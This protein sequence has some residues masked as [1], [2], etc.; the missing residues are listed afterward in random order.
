MTLYAPSSSVQSHC[1]RRRSMT[2]RLRLLLLL[3]CYSYIASNLPSIDGLAAAITSSTVLPSSAV[4]TA[5]SRNQDHHVSFDQQIIQDFIYSSSGSDGQESRESS[6]SSSSSSSS[7]LSRFHVHGWRWHTLSLARESGRLS[8]LAS[9]TTAKDL[10]EASRL[11]DAVSYVVDFNMK[12]LHKIEKQ[13][14]FPWMREKFTRSTSINN[15]AELSKAFTQV[16]DRLEKDQRHVAKLG[17]TISKNVEIACNPKKSERIRSEAVQVIADQSAQLEQTTRS[18][19]E[20]EDKLL[21]PS[22]AKIVPEDEQKSFSNKVLRNLGLMD[23]RL[24]LVG[25]YEAVNDLEGQSNVVEKDLFERSIPSIPQMMIPRWRRKLYE[26]RT[27][28]LSFI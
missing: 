22:I 1:C 27:K 2:F 13:V 12:G 20:V 23:S 3:V 14:F 7:L 6:S 25:M 4:D 11:K 9:R 19:I 5:S 24:H 18:M 21:V 15:D 8:S 17:D 26:P 16:M 10:D 28:D